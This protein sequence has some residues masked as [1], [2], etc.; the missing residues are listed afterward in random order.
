MH[1]FGWDRPPRC[2]IREQIQEAGNDMKPSRDI[3]GLIEVMA[4]LRT[5]AGRRILPTGEEDQCGFLIVHG[6]PLNRD[7]FSSIRHRA[8]SLCLSMIFSENRFPLFGIML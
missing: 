1:R 2:G 6:P 3:S 7:D 4:A 8:L 5:K